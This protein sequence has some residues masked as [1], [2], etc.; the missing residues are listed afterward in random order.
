MEENMKKYCAWLVP[1]AYVVVLLFLGT[2]HAFIPLSV[3]LLEVTKIGLSWQVLLIVSMSSIIFLFEEPIRLFLSS[4][5]GIEVDKLKV[6]CQQD[7]D[8]PESIPPQ[9]VIQLMSER[10]NQWQS[11]YDQAVATAQSAIDVTSRENQELR[12]LLNKF[13]YDKLRWQFTYAD[14]RLVL[15]TKHL[16]KLISFR[17]KFT[18]EAFSSEWGMIIP[19]LLEQNAMINVLL[20]LEFIDVQDDGF[21]IT[22]T[23]I[24]YVNYLEQSGQLVK[25]KNSACSEK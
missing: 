24:V 16:L 21:R 6:S 17:E 23:G 14:K 18:K 25:P 9:A 7:N 10:D 4:V 8:Q 3:N 2:L 13:Y 1:F 19:D 22:N 12:E 15:M 5:K 11:S 20:E